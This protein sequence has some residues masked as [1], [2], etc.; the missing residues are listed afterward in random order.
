VALAGHLST[1][2]KIPRS[3]IED[4]EH[5]PATSNLFEAQQSTARVRFQLDKQ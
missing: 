5:P 3:V 4:F 2:S 1:Q